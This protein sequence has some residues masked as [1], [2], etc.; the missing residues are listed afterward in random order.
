[1]PKGRVEPREVFC[2]ACDEPFI[3]DKVGRASH[4]CHRPECDE[5]R[6]ANKRR[7]RPRLPPTVIRA[8]DAELALPP[9]PPPE[10]PPPPKP[11][12]AEE[13][14]PL[15]ED[16]VMIG[17]LAADIGP[18]PRVLRETVMA[19]AKGEGDMRFFYRRLAAASLALAA[20]VGGHRL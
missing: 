12:L 14:G 7:G 10:R 13:F 19:V 8:L 9:P 3:S 2:K 5:D 17:R 1:M 20:Y 18:S 4:F 16:M 6:K 15:S 11:T